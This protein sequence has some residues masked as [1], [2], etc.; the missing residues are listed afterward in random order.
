MNAIFSFL[1]FTVESELD[2]EDRRLPTLDFK[3]WVR[4]EDGLI[5][6]TFYEKPTSS[7]Q[8]I[9][10]DTAL[11]ENTKMAT[12]NSEV[13]RRMLHTSELLPIEERIMVLDDMSQK[14]ANSGFKLAQTR[15]IMIGGLSR[16][17][18]LLRW[19]KLPVREGFRPP[20]LDAGASHS[21]RAKKKLTGKSDWYKQ[22]GT[23]KTKGQED[24]DKNIEE[25]RKEQKKEEKLAKR[26][27]LR[28]KKKLKKMMQKHHIGGN[29]ETTSVMFVENTPFGE[30]A[31]RLQECEDRLAEITGRRIKIVEMGGTKLGQALPNTNPWAGS[32][33][34]REDCH[35]CHQGGLGERDKKE[36]CFRRN[37]LYES[38]CVKCSDEEELASGRKRKITRR[39]IGSKS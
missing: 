28:A 19:S 25:A 13:V 3:L 6:H 18:K 29:I 10:K 17:E 5:M 27:K 4:Q 33:C 12:L 38:R 21:T 15:R 16:Y 2:F 35:T 22:G 39:T 7:N 31:R 9:Q 20:H 36:D 23:K 34:S 14:L 8:T 30:L 26:R 24:L 1:R 11:P 37:I 32:G